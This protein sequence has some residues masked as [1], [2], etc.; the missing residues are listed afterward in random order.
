MLEIFS[1]PSILKFSLNAI[2]IHQLGY[3]DAG[4]GCGVVREVFSFFWMEFYESQMLGESERVPCIM[5]DFGR[6]KW[7][8]VGRILVKGYTD[9]QCFP[10]KISKAFVAGFLFGEGSITCEMLLESFKRCVSNRR[11]LG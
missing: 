4:Q 5:H 9:S 3:E 1:D 6:N 8:A 7:G 11:L 2:V 10:H